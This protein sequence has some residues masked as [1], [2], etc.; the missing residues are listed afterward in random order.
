MAADIVRMY[1]LYFLI[2]LIVKPFRDRLD[3][4]GRFRKEKAN[5]IVILVLYERKGE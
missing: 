3:F 1:T 4:I 2:I 5:K